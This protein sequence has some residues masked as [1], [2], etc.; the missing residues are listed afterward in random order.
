MSRAKIVFIKYDNSDIPVLHELS[1]HSIQYECLSFEQL[2]N[3]SSKKS[4]DNIHG[5][6]IDLDDLKNNLD[7]AKGSLHVWKEVFTQLII[8]STNPQGKPSDLLAYTRHPSWESAKLAL[9]IGARDVLKFSQTQTTLI[10]KYTKQISPPK[11]FSVDS[12]NKIPINSLE[13]NSPAIEYIRTLVRKAAP[14]EAP[15]LL[16]GKTGTGKERVAQAIHKLSAF[17]TGP[18]VVVNCAAIPSELFESEM[19][20]HV[21]G[22]FTGA[23][24]DRQGSMQRAQ[25]GT[26]FLDEVAE[27]PLG[28]Q[29]KLLRVLQ[30][31]E[32]T[33]VGSQK[34]IP[35][36]IRLMSSSQY[37]LEELIRQQKFRED[38]YYRLKVL[39]IH[40][41]HLRERKSDIPT[42]SHSTIKRFARRNQHPCSRA[43]FNCPRKVSTLRLAR[44]YP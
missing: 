16:R 33:P 35:L 22:A 25:N 2:N 3:Y 21:K 15:V 44:Q 36:K 37:D 40:L 7:Q 28:F 34:S 41:P 24:A 29:S 19:F 11:N 17:S 8:S 13:G 23:H 18:F 6:L 30:E 1:K 31:N 42:I 43:L 9:Q 5:Y 4:V 32:V 39:E 12:L 38:L 26:L 27:L 20:G 10:Q 14:V